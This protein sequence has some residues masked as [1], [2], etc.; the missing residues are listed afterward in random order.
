[1]NKLLVLYLVVFFSACNNTN[2]I[3]TNLQQKYKTTGSIER[4]D[5]SL[6]AIIDAAATPEIIADGMDWSEGPIWIEKYKMLLFSDV[7]RDTIFKW[8]EKYGKEFYLSPSGYT[9]TIKR[10][11]E[12]GS[13]G[14]TLDRNGNLILCQCGDR[15]IARMDAPLNKPV[16]KYTSLADN[17][18]GK[19]FNSPNDVMCDSKGEIFFTDPP[20]GLEKQMNDPKKE[21]SFQGVFKIKTNGTVVLITDTLTRPNGIAFLPGEKTLLVANSDPAKPNWYAFELDENGG[22]ISSRIFYSAAGYDKSLKGL[23]DGMKIDKQG[24]VFAAGPGGVWIFNSS[25]KLLGK[26]KLPEATSNIA[27]TPDDKTMYITNDMYILRVKLRS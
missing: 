16:A 18:N 19:K 7:T 1:M 13:N 20:Y 2:K 25:G 27:L 9:G 12:M 8:T 21:I 24:N 4:I 6:D 10:G 23:P 22:V 11:G 3:N 26:I 5:P 17:F 15:Q 14:L